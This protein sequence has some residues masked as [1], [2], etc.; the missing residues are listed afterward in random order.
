MPTMVW[1]HGTRDRGEEKTF[2][3]DGATVK[4]Y[5]DLDQNL[6]TSNGFMAVSAG[7]FGTPNDQQGPG[8][9]T[10]VTVYNYGVF[11]DLEKRDYVAML[12][13]DN[14]PLMFIG[15]EIP[16]GHLCNDLEGCKTA[17]QHNCDGVLG[18]AKDSEIVILVCRGLPGTNTATAKYGKDDNPLSD[19]NED[20]TKF[21]N[22]WYPKIF[23]DPAT[24]EREFDDFS[25]PIKIMVRGA[26]GG[27]GAWQAV[28]WAAD[29][30]RNGKVADLFP[31]LREVTNDQAAVE[32]LKIGYYADGVVA[33]AKADPIEF[34]T[35]MRQYSGVAIDA[36]AALPGLAA[37]KKSYEDGMKAFA[38][39]T[40]SPD[41]T[42]LDQMNIT[43]GANVKGVGDGDSLAI[44]VG[45]TMALIGPGHDLKA[46]NYVERQGDFER[47]T[48]SVTKGGPFSKGGIK[49]AGLSAGKQGLVEMVVKEFSAKPVTFA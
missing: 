48:I 41:N 12:N 15:A 16:E 19:I 2:V 13:R 6:F 21:V 1:G 20:M 49:V 29:A 34:F 9:G 4:W 31:Q 10:E 11:A 3:P 39:S 26:Y 33:G 27:I 43:N 47:G 25:D 17:G 5:S 7:Q 28:R 24:A 46:V 30:G 45:G 18:R 35:S 42:A 38:D 44:M 32:F 8:R 37:A 22:D 23:S 36:I 14:L 40:W